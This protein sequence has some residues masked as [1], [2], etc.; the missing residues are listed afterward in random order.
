MCYRVGFGRFGSSKNL[1]AFQP[2]RF[3]SELRSQNLTIFV[4]IFDRGHLGLGQY[5]DV[6]V[7][8][9]LKRKYTFSEAHLTA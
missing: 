4:D 7:L 2:R 1:I 9:L 6:L 8:F 5:L 3:N